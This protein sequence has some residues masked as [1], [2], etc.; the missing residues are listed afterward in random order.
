MRQ[1]ALNAYKKK[2]SIGFKH[3]ADV[4]RSPWKQSKIYNSKFCYDV[5]AFLQILNEKQM[6]LNALDKKELLV[7]LHAASCLL[8]SL[9]QALD[10]G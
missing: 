8:A 5:T 6:I 9:T 3:H 10:L 4:R 7:S 2:G 1:K